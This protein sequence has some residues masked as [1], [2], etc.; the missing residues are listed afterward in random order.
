MRIDELASVVTTGGK[1][2]GN[3]DSYEADEAK[4]K[5]AIQSWSVSDG[6]KDAVA[7]EKDQA[8]FDFNKQLLED[9]EFTL[10]TFKE[11]LESDYKAAKESYDLTT[12]PYEEWKDKLSNDVFKFFLYENYI[13]PEYRKVDG[14]EDKTKIDSINLN[15]RHVIRQKVPFKRRG[16]LEEECKNEKRHVCVVFQQY[17]GTRCALFHTLAALRLKAEIRQYNG[18]NHHNAH[19]P[20]RRRHTRRRNERV[21][22]DNTGNG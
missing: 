13:T 19:H 2:S 9:Y 22:R 12:A 4:M 8:S 11:E 7:S 15:I 20:E 3:N 6:Y 21:Y 14:R 16:H 17:A 18:G 10:K 1:I 5:E